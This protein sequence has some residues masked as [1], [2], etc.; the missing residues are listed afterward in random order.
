MLWNYY[1]LRQLSLLQ[2]AMDTC[3]KLRHGLLQI[4]TGITKCDGFITNRDRYY[5]VRLLLQIA[6]V[7]PFLVLLGDGFSLTCKPRQ[8]YCAYC[9]IRS[10]VNLSTSL[11]MYMEEGT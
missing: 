2:S 11:Y 4:T 10:L 8:T 1:K 7:K 5:K 9:S 3:Y 6:T